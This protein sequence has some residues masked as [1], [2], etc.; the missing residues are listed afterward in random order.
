MSELKHV[1]P[2]KA[3]F[4]KAWAVSRAAA[5][6]FQAP[7]RSFFAAALRQAW[8]EAKSLAATI[9]GQRARVLA[10]VARI[11]VELTAEAAHRRVW[12][13]RIAMSRHRYARPVVDDP[14][15]FLA[16]LAASQAAATPRAA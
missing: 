13:S 2:L 9:A 12:A 10:E 11:K 1:Y 8:A 6:R 16:R 4:T 15:G 5:R 7:V 14:D 3:L